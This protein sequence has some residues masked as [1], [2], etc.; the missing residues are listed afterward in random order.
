[1]CVDIYICIKCVVVWVR[2]IVTFSFSFSLSHAKIS[3]QMCRPSR[4]LG[5]SQIFVCVCVLWPVFM[6]YQCVCVRGVDFQNICK[7]Y[8]LYI[9]HFIWNIWIFSCSIPFPLS[10]AHTMCVCMCE[11]VNVN[12]CIFKFSSRYFNCLIDR[13]IVRSCCFLLLFYFTVFC[14]NFDVFLS[15]LV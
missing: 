14:W 9:I 2:L 8:F 11:S 1:M 10:V 15:Q 4:W 7:G 6:E 12:V 3:I 13:S 5:L